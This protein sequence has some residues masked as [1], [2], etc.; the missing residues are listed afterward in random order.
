SELEPGS[1]RVARRLGQPSRR[2]SDAGAHCDR[3]RCTSSSG[4]DL[5]RVRRSLSLGMTTAWL[6]VVVALCALLSTRSAHACGA[7][8]DVPEYWD[9]QF[10]SEGDVSI[11]TNFGLILQREGDWL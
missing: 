2:S 5:G 3:V 6:A 9:L 7:T 1:I 11:V 4:L 8:C 10:S